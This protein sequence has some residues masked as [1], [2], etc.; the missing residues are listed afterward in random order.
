MSGLLLTERGLGLL[1]V[2]LI[3][4]SIAIVFVVMLSYVS[5]FY[6]LGL[7]C[8]AL[9]SAIFAFV[10]VIFGVIYIVA[11]KDEYEGK[12]Q[13]AVFLGL[14]FILVSVVIF[15]YD[16]FF[17]S[18][19]SREMLVYARILTVSHISGMFLTVGLG[20]L[21]HNLLSKGY[22][23]VLWVGL[24]LGMASATFGAFYI[25]SFI[26]G[27]IYDA[28][29]DEVAS[30][31]IISRLGF[32]F[33]IVGMPFFIVCVRRALRS[34]RYEEIEPKDKTKH[35]SKYHERAWLPEYTKTQK[36]ID[37]PEK[38]DVVPYNPLLEKE[39]D[40]DTIKLEIDNKKNEEIATNEVTKEEEKEIPSCPDCGALFMQGQQFCG[41]CGK[42]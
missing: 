20:L 7:F 39:K 36:K 34:V 5:P 15:T 3:A 6:A 26:S 24:L 8:G 22:R 35:G 31:Q 9:V 33:Y 13:R 30:Y 10:L 27:R 25:Y 37:L 41:S 16:Y 14:V 29:D 19:F 4:L 42:L 11:G 12:H 21:I 38:F 40:E 2:G 17:N 18:N 23:K 1:Y 28:F 32:S